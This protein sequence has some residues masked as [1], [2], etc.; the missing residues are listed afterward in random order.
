MTDHL[1]PAL[2]RRLR[3]LE[4]KIG[5]HDFHLV[6][7]QLLYWLQGHPNFG[8]LLAEALHDYGRFLE[9][10]ESRLQSHLQEAA[11]ALTA[12]ISAFPEVA[13]ND[14]WTGPDGQPTMK[15]K[16]SLQRAQD[17]VEGRDLM[18]SAQPLSAPR[19]AED[20]TSVG[21]L[22]DILWLTVSNALKAQTPTANG[23]DPEQLFLQLDYLE[24]RQSALIAELQL[25]APTLAGHALSQLLRW[26]EALV[27]TPQRYESLRARG[28][29]FFAV[30]FQEAQV[31]ADIRTEVTAGHQ[32]QDKPREE[33]HRHVA[34]LWS[35]IV[36]DAAERA[37]R[38]A[39]TA[40]SGP[41]E[42]TRLL[43]MTA[44]TPDEPLWIEAETQSVREALWS[45]TDREALNASFVST[46]TAVKVM[47]ELD[48]IQP[49]ILHVSCH[50]DVAGLTLVDERGEADPFDKSRVLEALELARGLRLVV[51]MACHSVELAEEA[52]SHVDVAVGMA[53]EVPDEDAPVFSEAFYLALA[54][55]FS[56]KEA[57]DRALAALRT[58][59]GDHEVPKLF[60][61]EG[62]SVSD[63]RF[64]RRQGRVR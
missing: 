19:F 59:G 20:R 33:L 54:Q 64:G 29:A 3:T 60:V 18:A 46:V 23:A 50:G 44:N 8:V 51:L 62:V 42:P 35:L 32:K 9:A 25:V 48:R 11:D 14:G 13:P 28:S 17:I 34:E 7:F 40:H 39:V 10:Y 15:Y 24:A 53:G 57:F 26:R 49:H 36:D 16:F 43:M 30:P 52:T 61:R 47:R 58:V 45:A 22:I 5:T 27:S 38:S 21:A 37:A 12:V 41:L 4:S 55:D 2:G 63:V 1:P 56:V 6:S 31:L